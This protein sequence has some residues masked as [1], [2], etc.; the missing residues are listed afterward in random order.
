MSAAIKRM[1]D[2][3][4]HECGKVVSI[5]HGKAME[6][7]L[8]ELGLIEGT[9]IECTVR[10]PHGDMAA[11]LVRGACIALRNSDSEK[12]LCSCDSVH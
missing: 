4:V 8:R 1:S 11:F 7:R 10:S 2:M 6:K 5:K 3:S 12:I 9:Y